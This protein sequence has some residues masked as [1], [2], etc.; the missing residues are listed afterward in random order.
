[1]S[2]WEQ[3]FAG[4]YSAYERDPHSAAEVEGILFEDATKIVNT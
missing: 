3:I 1:M 2:S 4:M